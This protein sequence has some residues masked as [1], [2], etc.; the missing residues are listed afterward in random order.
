MTTIDIKDAKGNKAGSADLAPSVFGIEPNVPVMHQVVRA[1]RASWRQGTHD[2][3]TRGEVRGGG[4]KPW[5]QKGTG[6]ARQGTIRAPQWAG[7]G[8]VFGPHPRS[9]AFRVNNKEVKLA[10]R[11]ALSAKLADGEL[12][13]IDG[14]NFE[15]PCTKDAVAILKAF[16]LEG[17]TTIVISDDDVNA[18]LSFRN[19]PTVNILPVGAAN[20]YEIIDNK[21]IVF[22]AAALKRIEEVLA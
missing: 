3:K 17:R 18:Y 21:A 11:S 12:H 13:V 19:I 6:R 5:R 4:K 15:K 10:M 20:T 2:T 8:T 9:Y 22:T 7:G 16:G 14:F 1:Q